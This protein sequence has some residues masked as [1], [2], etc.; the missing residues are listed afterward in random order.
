[1]LK[2]R[3]PLDW[4]RETCEPATRFCVAGVGRRFLGDWLTGAAI[5]AAMT[6]RCARVIP[7][8]SCGR[9]EHGRDGSKQLSEPDDCA[10]INRRTEAN[11]SPD[12]FRHSA[13][14]PLLHL[15][16]YKRQLLRFLGSLRQQP[17]LIS[18]IT[19]APSVIVVM[20]ETEPT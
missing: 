6:R 7:K 18:H 19:S 13:T 11:E 3:R 5:A 20:D 4:S 16:P 17:M 8:S 14:A 9:C 1:N 2:R 12:V 15:N 10:E